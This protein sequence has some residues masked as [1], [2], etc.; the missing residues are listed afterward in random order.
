VLR[1]LKIVSHLKHPNIVQLKDVIIPPS[2]EGFQ[3]LY[4]VTDLMETDLRNI[5]YVYRNRILT[6]HSRS[7]QK[8]SDQH[9]QFITFQM[10]AA[11]NYTHSAS[12]LHRDIK[13]EN[14]LIN[15][16]STIKLCDFGLARFIDFEN[17][18]T[19][20]TNYV[21]TRWYRAPEL[22][23]NNKHVSKA[24]DV[25]SVGCIL[26][27]LLTG[28]VLFRGSSPIDQI[29]KIVHTLGSPDKE[30]VKGSP[31]G[32]EFL[33]RLGKFKGKRLEDI[34][35]NVNPLAIDLLSKLLTFNPEDRISAADAMKHPYMADF[36]DEKVAITCPD[37]F[38]FSYEENLKST[39]NIK[40]E[41]INTVFKVTNCGY[42]M[43]EERL[44]IPTRQPSSR[45]NGGF[46]SMFR[47]GST[48]K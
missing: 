42:C 10:L 39:S 47:R 18:P 8:L 1:E 33:H 46:F 40:L 30:N 21:Q 3:D 2:Y 29:Q 31:E 28:D 32:I 17:D 6:I 14:I 7:K 36:Y 43:N 9:I 15:S 11:L 41:M 35:L 23:L 25:W 37:D 48:S 12:I 44:I 19:M 22:L 16:D 26:A 4:F 20:S 27:E 13:P 34:F 45:A 24:A 38:D 5:M